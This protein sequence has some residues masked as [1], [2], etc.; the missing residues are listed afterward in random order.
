MAMQ[1][2]CKK[3]TERMAI[4][5]WSVKSSRCLL[6]NGNQRQG[7][8]PCRWKYNFTKIPQAAIENPLIYLDDIMPYSCSPAVL[9]LFRGGEKEDGDFHYHAQQQLYQQ[10][11]SHPLTAAAACHTATARVFEAGFWNG[12]MT[13]VNTPSNTGLCVFLLSC[14]LEES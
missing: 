12:D 1:W 13:S 14:M 7:K 10:Q 4:P 11:L 8:T 6:S 3:L 2:K 5:V 9:S